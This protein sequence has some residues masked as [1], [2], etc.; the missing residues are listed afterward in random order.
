MKNGQVRRSFL[1]F[2]IATAISGLE[3][4]QNDYETEPVSAAKIP[5]NYF[6]PAR[7]PPAFLSEP[8]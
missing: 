8:A 1:N 3:N 6:F 5:C 7:L 4:L 2:F